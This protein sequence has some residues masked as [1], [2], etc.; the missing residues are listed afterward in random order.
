MSIFHVAAPPW[1]C[2]FVMGCMHAIYV[3]IGLRSRQNVPEKC[4][5]IRL[6][7]N[8]VGQCVHWSLGATLFRRLWTIGLCWRRPNSFGTIRFGHGTVF[9]R[10]CNPNLCEFFR[11]IGSES[12]SRTAINQDENC[13]NHDQLQ[14]N[15][16]KKQF[17]ELSLKSLVQR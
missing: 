3:E 4:R 12:P 13:Q 10:L 16:N 17:I 8:V 11:M 2:N 9:L 6:F 14:H 15:S 7:C 5:I 1:G